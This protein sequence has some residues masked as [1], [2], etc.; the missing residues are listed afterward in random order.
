MLIPAFA[1]PGRVVCC[2]QASFESFPGFYRR[3]AGE[4]LCVV[5][6]GMDISRVDEAV[7][8]Y[9]QRNRDAQFTVVSVGRLIDVKNP[10][11]ALR[12]FQSTDDRTSRLLFI[13]EGYLRGALTRE[14]NAPGRDRQIELIGLVQREQVYQHLT[15][16]DLFI[17][18]SLVEGLPIAVL[19]AMACGCPVVSSGEAFRDVLPPSCLATDGGM[20]SAAKDILGSSAE[21]REKLG[22][23]LRTIVEEHHGLA[24]LVDLLVRKMQ[25]GDKA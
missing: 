2:S 19:E 1:F 10:L 23:E 12:A 15:R 25:T 24:R 18:T 7:G 5:P 17:S 9:R 4:R 21:D 3:L 16:A 20:A 14:S 6:N 13:G 11:V 8:N 22:H